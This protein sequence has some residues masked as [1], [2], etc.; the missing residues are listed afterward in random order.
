M[1][2]KPKRLLLS[3]TDVSEHPEAVNFTDTPVTGVLVVT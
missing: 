2:L 3:G 1:S